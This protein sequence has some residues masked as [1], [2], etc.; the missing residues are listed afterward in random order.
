MNQEELK[1]KYEKLKSAY[2]EIKSNYDLLVQKIKVERKE[3]QK[4]I[5]KL[6]EIIVNQDTTIRELERLKRNGTN[7]L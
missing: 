6:E 5:K 1:E 3:Y 7:N 2:T 4:K